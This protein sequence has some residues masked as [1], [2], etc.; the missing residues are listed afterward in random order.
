MGFKV[1]GGSQKGA[2]IEVIPVEGLLRMQKHALL[3]STAPYSG[4]GFV[5]PHCQPPPRP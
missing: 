2:P 1:I 4:H 5:H 3:E